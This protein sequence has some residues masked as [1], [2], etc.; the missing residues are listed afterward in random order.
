MCVCVCVYIYMC[1]YVCVC[2]CVCVTNSLY[3]MQ[4]LIQHC[5]L[6]ILWFLKIKLK[7]ISAKLDSE[8]DS[9]IQSIW[10]RG[11]L[12]EAPSNRYER[13][14]SIESVKP[15]KGVRNLMRKTN[16]KCAWSNCGNSLSR[17]DFL[18]SLHT[19]T[20][21][22]LSVEVLSILY[23]HFHLILFQGLKKSVPSDHFSPFTLIASC[24][25]WSRQALSSPEISTGDKGD[26]PNNGNLQGWGSCR[27]LSEPVGMC[28]S[29]PKPRE[30]VPP[31]WDQKYSGRKF[32]MHA[33]RILT[34]LPQCSPLKWILICFRK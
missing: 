7:T 9:T 29:S 25:S 2:V 24:F 4:N 6:T 33:A 34:Q 19:G 3:C 10:A 21:R 5:K 14:L 31:Q 11:W 17:S 26:L 28:I 15:T 30:N 27:C 16:L 22:I 18:W 8:L 23:W 1:V 32:L 20:G 13:D 12:F